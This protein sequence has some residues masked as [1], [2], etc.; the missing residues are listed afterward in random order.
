MSAPTNYQQEEG[1][2]DSEQVSLGKERCKADQ[3]P[4]AEIATPGLIR[5]V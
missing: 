5:E 2:G 1:D 3:L 4:W